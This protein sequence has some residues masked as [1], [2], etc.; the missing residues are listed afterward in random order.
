MNGEITPPYTEPDE[1]A[2]LLQPVI[3]WP[4]ASLLPTQGWLSLARLVEFING[5]EPEGEAR[6]VVYKGRPYLHDGHH[7]W[8]V[9][10][11][12]GAHQFFARTIVVR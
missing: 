1:T 7:R 3:D 11:A 12:R 10:L 6:V 2:W 5:G 4:I 8:T 9:A